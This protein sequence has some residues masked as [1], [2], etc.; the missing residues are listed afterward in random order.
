MTLVKMLQ[1]RKGSEDGFKVKQFYEGQI[2]DI[3][4]NLARTFF[5]DGYA[6]NYSNTYN[7]KQNKIIL[8]SN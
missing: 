6:E 8:S 7:K 1:T 4:E 2:Y 5:A 3:A